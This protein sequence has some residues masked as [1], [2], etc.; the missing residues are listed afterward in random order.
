MN[1]PLNLFDERG[2]RCYCKDCYLPTWHS[3]LDQAGETYVIPRGWVRFGLVQ[4]QLFSEIN[5]IWDSWHNVFHGTTIE[6][7]IGIAKHRTLLHVGDTTMD[8]VDIGKR[9]SVMASKCIYVSPHIEYSA[10]PWYS[11]IEYFG[12]SKSGQKLYG[13]VVMAIKMKPGTFD[14]QGETEGGAKKFLDNY[15]PI[16]ESEIE[17]YTSR[18]GCVIPYG[19]LFRILDEDGKKKAEQTFEKH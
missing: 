10:H 5:D 15:G 16:N 4:C 3:Q 1:Y 11:K 14:R 8:G 17:W 13:Q 7:S 18:R 12:Q 19:I 9:G 6:G 2:N